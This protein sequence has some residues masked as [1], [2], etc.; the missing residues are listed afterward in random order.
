MPIWQYLVFITLSTGYSLQLKASYL[1]CNEMSSSLMRRRCQ[2]RCRLYLP[3]VAQAPALPRGFPDLFRLVLCIHGSIPPDVRC[4]SEAGVQ[5]LNLAR[6]I[7]SSLLPSRFQHINILI[8]DLRYLLC[9]QIKVMK[10]SI[11][12]LTYYFGR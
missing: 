5:S 8:R 4:A 11:S 7:N 3:T 9:I 2:N 6:L 10:L 1:P 12:S